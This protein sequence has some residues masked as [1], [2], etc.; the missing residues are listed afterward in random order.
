MLLHSFLFL[1]LFLVNRSLSVHFAPSTKPADASRE[2]SRRASSRHR[3]FRGGPSPA[4][5]R[6]G[7]AKHAYDQAAAAAAAAAAAQKA[8]Y[9][10]ATQSTNTASPTPS[11]FVGAT[12]QAISSFLRGSGSNGRATSNSHPISNHRTEP[13]V[14]IRMLDAG[15]VA[16]TKHGIRDDD[17]DSEESYDDVFPNRKDEW[18]D[19]PSKS[20]R[21]DEDSI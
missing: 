18:S 16:G 3:S 9:P 1:L 8:V 15:Q 20:Q 21:T 10:D 7:K 11:G 6:S 17:Y 5:T 19:H 12:G 14:D 4:R 2:R 13:D